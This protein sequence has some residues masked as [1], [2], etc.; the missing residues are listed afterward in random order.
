[1]W[2]P[3][4]ACRPSWVAD[5]SGRDFPGERRGL[6]RCRGDGRL[7]LALTLYALTGIAWYAIADF[8]GMAAK[9]RATRTSPA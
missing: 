4:F 2:L 3:G 9:S 6:R 5:R 7:P 1:M 8:F